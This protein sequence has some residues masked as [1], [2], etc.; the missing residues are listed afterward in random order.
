MTAHACATRHTLCYGQTT[1]DV[2]SPQ[3][4]LPLSAPSAGIARSPAGPPC[5]FKSGHGAW[6]ACR[7]AGAH[8]DR[9]RNHAAG[10]VRRPSRPP[11]PSGTVVQQQRQHQVHGHIPAQSGR[12]SSEDKSWHSPTPWHGSRPCHYIS[13]HAQGS[14][15]QTAGI[16]CLDMQLAALHIRNAPNHTHNCCDLPEA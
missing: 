16:V 10:D 6:H 7:A 4:T 15:S 11:R 14:C 13:K 5:D 9:H 1:C 8:S 3:H 12:M 2:P